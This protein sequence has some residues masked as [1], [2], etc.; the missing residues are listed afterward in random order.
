MSEVKYSLNG[1]QFKDFGVYVSES[2]NLAG[3]LERKQITQYDW[4]EYHGISPDLS[5]PRYKEREI[6]LKCFIR[7]EN[8][9]DLFAN[10]RDLVI[11][12][13]SKAGT[14][15]L[16]VQPM[17]FK[18]LAYEVF[19]KDEVQI[20]KQFS[21]GEMFATFTLKMIEPN[22]IKKIFKTSLDSFR[23]KYDSPS[24]T[25]IFIGDGTKLIGRGNVNF[26]FDYSEP[27]YQPSGISLVQGSAFNNTYYE[28]YTIPSGELVYQ[29]SVNVTLSTAKNIILYVIG[30]KPDNTYGL[31]KA[32]AIMN[33]NTGLNTIST[34]S[35]IN[36]D[37][38]AKFFFKV[39]DS[40]GAEI[41]GIVYSNPWIETAEVVGEW[42]NM[43]GKEK[44]I[45]I[46]GD[47]DDVKNVETPAEI[48][49][50]KI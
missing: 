44:I 9:E 26:L 21:Q 19:M 46:A 36:L 23:L 16:Q 15:R 27:T 48:I 43:L 35:E 12:D 20:E 3:M 6:E 40:Q 18:T 37:D 50:D 14:Q 31:V 47:I 25:E 28:M 30:R 42:Q 10:F 4:A 11:S 17:G 2:S 5:R 32:S 33:G 34:T 7:G 49:W 13:F 38:Y 1:K 22:P 39:L 24:E 29:F 41:P 8:W 45:I